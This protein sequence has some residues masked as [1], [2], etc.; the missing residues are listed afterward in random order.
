MKVVVASSSP[1]A[2][3]LISA[4]K[5]SNNHQL[6]FLLTNPDKATGRGLHVVA[7]ELAIWADKMDINIEKLQTQKKQILDDLGQGI[8]FLFKKNNINF[9]NSTAQLIGKNQRVSPSTKF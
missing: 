5:A 4:L 3:P 6:L 2:I 1:V 9:I 8:E 7:N